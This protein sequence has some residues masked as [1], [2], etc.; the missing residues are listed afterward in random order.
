MT[1]Y[2]PADA[3]KFLFDLVKKQGAIDQETAITMLMHEFG[4]SVRKG[5]G[6]AIHPSILRELSKLK[7]EL[8]VWESQYKRWH[9]IGPRENDSESDSQDTA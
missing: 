2:Q 5:Y 4:D 8:I 7:G 9:W 6:Y 3:A 1:D